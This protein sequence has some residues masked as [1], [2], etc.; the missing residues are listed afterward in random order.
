MHVIRITSK[1]L[2]VMNVIM[3]YDICKEM[4]RQQVTNTSIKK[5]F[6]YNNEQNIVLTQ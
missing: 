1:S 4:C 6:N 2:I 5:R 3:C